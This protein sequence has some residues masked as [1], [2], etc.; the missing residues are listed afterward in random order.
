[1]RWRTI[2]RDADPFSV[3]ST[4]LDQW[5]LT[6]LFVTAFGVTEFVLVS[7]LRIP[8]LTAS[9]ARTAFA[10]RCSSLGAALEVFARVFATFAWLLITL[11]FF[12]E[13]PGGL[14]A[15]VVLVTLWFVV[16]CVVARRTYMRTMNVLRE[17]VRRL[18]VLFCFQ[19]PF[20]L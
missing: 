3:G 5:V 14:I 13:R 8:A 9:Y 2:A 19:P 16:A 11:L 10:R 7:A 20:L 12:V 6:A 17:E 4:L 15:M 1:M 18:L